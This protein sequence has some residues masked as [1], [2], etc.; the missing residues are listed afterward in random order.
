MPIKNYNDVSSGDLIAGQIYSDE[1]NTVIRSGFNSETA[2]ILPAGFAYCRA[3]SSVASGS[4][5]G[6]PLILPVDA[7][8]RFVGIGFVPRGLEKRSGYSLNT[9][10]R[11]GYPVDYEVSYVVKGII[12]VEVDDT[13]NYGDPVF[14]RH[15]ATGD[16]RV[17]MFRIDADTSDA[18]QIGGVDTCKFMSDATGT[19]ASPAIALISINI[20]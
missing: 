15:T 8:S 7:N 10:D 9:D 6:L 19:A 17:G 14:W 11:F 18:V 4:K 5:L 1:A 16:E 3:A 13:V 20:A 2:E 12:A